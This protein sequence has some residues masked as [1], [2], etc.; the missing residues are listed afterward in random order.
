MFLYLVQ[1]AEAKPEAEDPLRPL[2]DAGQRTAAQMAELFARLG[3][4]PAAIWHSDKL[5]ARQTAQVYAAHVPPLRGISQVAGLAPLDDV[6]P[7]AAKLRPQTEDLM[8]VGHLPHLSRLASLLLLG[9]PDRSIL[10]FQ[11][12]GVV[13]LGR[14]GS[15]VWSL[16][17]MLPPDPAVH[18]LT[19]PPEDRETSVYE[20][21]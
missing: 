11:M 18:L 5:R 7:L 3:S 14:E 10:D 8:L 15:G 4:R 2:S 20:T 13:C 1:H 9:D 17:W 16:R 12:A 19:L 6:A 21:G